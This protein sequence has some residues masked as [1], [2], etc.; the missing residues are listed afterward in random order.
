M[1]RA[2]RLFEQILDYHNI[3][4]AFLAAIRGNRESPAVI[5]FC[6]NTDKNLAVIREKLR[7]LECNWGVTVPL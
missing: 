2:G 1:K 4:G 3:R 5:R 7:S 6:R